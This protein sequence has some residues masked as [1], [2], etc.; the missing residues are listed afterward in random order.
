MG[1]RTEQR[2]AIRVPILVHGI[3]RQGFPFTVTGET[4]DI[5]G[6]GA[7][8]YGLN[9]VGTPGSKVEVEYHSRKA[10]FRIQWLG[11]DGSSREGTVGLR[12]LEPGKFIW[13]SPIPEWAEDT[14]DPSQPPPAAAESQSPK[15]AQAGNAAPAPWSGDERRKYPRHPCRIEALVTTEDSSIRL[16]G[17]VSDISLNGCY[18]EMLSP[19]PHDTAVEMI[20][21]PGDSTLHIFGRVVTTQMG[22]G[23]GISFTAVSPD[24]F[25]KLRN[26][27]PPVTELRKPVASALRVVP[28]VSA[29]AG[30]ARAPWTAP[31][32][33]PARAPVATIP[34]PEKSAVAES[35]EAIVRALIRKGLLSRED[36]DQ[37]LA[38]LK[39]VR[40]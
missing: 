18:V 21:N 35:L 28:N 6:S 24:D 9:G 14:Y 31:P 11:R 5:S 39:S 15:A 19:L 40:R 36:L 17:K 10:V 2:I 25:E 23:M 16:P 26:L 7:C 32:P 1:R 30:Y 38:D 3:D 37:E 27:A 13:D 4:R 22:L 8:V 12:C 33:P 29:E 34:Q 20:L